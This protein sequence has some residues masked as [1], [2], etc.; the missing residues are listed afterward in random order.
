MSVIE[1]S[2]ES[3]LLFG[4]LF[5]YHSKVLIF[6]WSNQSDY[7]HVK[8]H[9]FKV[10]LTFGTFLFVNKINNNTYKY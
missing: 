4:K 2:E 10:F 5:H 9:I 7:N 3:N 1:G 8:S 6:S